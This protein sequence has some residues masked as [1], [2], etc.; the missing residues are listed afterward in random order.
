MDMDLDESG[1][2]SASDEDQVNNEPEEAMEEPEEE[3]KEESKEEVKEEPKEEVN[4]EPKEEFKEEVAQES[5]EEAPSDELPPHDDNAEQESNPEQNHRDEID[6][7]A[8]KQFEADLESTPWL[9]FKHLDGYFFGL[10]SLVKLAGHKPEYPDP[11]RQEPIKPP[12]TNKETPKPRPYNPYDSSDDI[13]PCYL[14]VDQK[15]AAP[16]IYAYDGVPQHMPDPAMGSHELLGLRNDVCFDRFGRYGPYG[17]G[18]NKLEGGTG[19]GIDTED[20]ES[21]AVWSKS[22]RINYVGMDWGGAQERCYEANKHRFRELDPETQE[23]KPSD[24]KKGRIAVVV[25]LYT[26]FRWTEHVLLN[27]RA[28]VNELSL[29]SGGEY[30]IHFLMHVKDQDKP[31]WADDATVQSLLD[32]NVPREFHNMV[33]LWSEPQMKL[34]YP[35]TFEDA[36]SNPSG[37]DIHGV[38]R[39]AHMPLQVFAL[40][41][42]EY[43]H[44]WN[45]EMD[46]RY[47]GSYYELFDRVAK[48]AE[49][50]PRTLL[51]ERNERYYIPS[52]HGSWENFTSVV[53]E[54]SNHSGRPEIFGPLKFP[55]LKPLRH[56]QGGESVMPPSC[57]GEGD[58][59]D[60]GVG[61]QADLI[62][63]NPIFDTDLSGWI[64]GLDATGYGPS[65]P[66]RCAII[67]ASRMSRRLLMAMHEEVWRHHHSMFSEMFPSSVALHHGYKAVYAPHPVFL[68]RAW[69]PPSS[70]DAAFNG[71]RDHSAS[72]NGSP[73]DLKNEHNHKGTSWYFHSEFAGL[74]WRRWLG[75]SQMDGRGE[76]GGRANEGS[77]R[78][79]KEEESAV[80]GTGRMCL[81]SMLAHP[82]KFE[83]PMEK[84]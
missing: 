34:M 77:E 65:P 17:L 28:L 62:T 84:N 64:F 70:I 68:D 61:E 12:P 27:F 35:G 50:Q 76:F 45:W 21:D 71:G 14:D 20:S 42:P 18:Y 6:E 38:Y 54:N 69:N 53:Q 41:H 26:D 60:C 36:V 37:Q 32:A 55:E 7:E 33:T 16:D 3:I 11:S 31:I 78:G 56:E 73:Y 49:K 15:V 67:T 72:G 82:I 10:K 23:L 83:G 47:V 46:M 39:S 51:W 63:F 4:E 24:T 44:I 19:V 1:D 57:I 25:R 5:K 30:D 29:K 74:L 22:G 8:R 48:W 43:E 66:R 58:K 79:G 75:Y 9:R 2:E 52:Y 59:A 40:N 81:R 80:H 13:K